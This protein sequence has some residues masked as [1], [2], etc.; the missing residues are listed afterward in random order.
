MNIEHLDGDAARDRF[1]EIEAV[2]AEAF[3]DYDLGDYRARIDR[4]L[5]TPGFE[6][7][8]VREEGV[9][10][11]FAY[12]APLKGS[13]WWDGL[14][15]APP[16]GFTAETG[17]RTFAVID[18]AVRPSHHGRGLGRRLLDEL[19]AGRVEERATLATAPHEHE[20]Q[21]MYRRWGWRHA[22]RTPGGE[23]ETEPWFDLY[24]IALRSDDP[25][26]SSSR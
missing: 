12:G 8:T 1:G 2:Y 3:P 24:V 17:R 15:P 23:G 14:E 22:G 26:A 18:L 6:A 16:A 25:E 11:G 19:L 10:A 20:I 5:R 9:L 7:V 21:A 4:L 13:S